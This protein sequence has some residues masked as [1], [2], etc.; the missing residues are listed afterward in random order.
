[1]GVLHV[2]A[3]AGRRHPFIAYFFVLIWPNAL[4]SVANLLYNEK[5]IVDG[6]A[7]SLRQKEAFW[8]LAVPLYTGIT[9][10]A[11]MGLGAWLIRPVFLYF[12]ALRRTEA[13]SAILKQ[14]A[15][16][17]LINLP[18]YQLWSNFLLWIPGA[19]YFPLMIYFFG[20]PENAAWIAAQ[21]LA[22]FTVSAVVTTFQTF[23]LLERFLLVYFYPK[24]FTDVR[25]TDV[26]GSVFLPF[27]MRLWFLW[28]AVSLG[29]IIVLVLI[30]LNLLPGNPGLMPLTVGVLIFSIVTGAIILGAVGSDMG[31]WLET[32]VAATR[33]IALGR[34]RRAYRRASLG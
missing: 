3:L 16:K 6:A 1:M 10:I 20:G 22:S 11:G 32:H 21:F 17:R 25:P 23:V 27:Q 13:V 19:A 7:V 14:A 34:F 9:W 5:L 4:W 18:W 29:P 33:Q 12:R 15:Q 8:N 24:V 2:V 28:G 30:T 31:H 26:Q